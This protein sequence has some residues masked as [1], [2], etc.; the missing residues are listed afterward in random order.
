LIHL[1]IVGKGLLLK[2]QQLIASSC[3]QKI[4]LALSTTG[5]THV[6]NLVRIINSTYNQVNCNLQILEEEGIIKI[7]HYGHMK[8]IELEKENPKTQALL[9][10]LQILNLPSADSLAQII[11]NNKV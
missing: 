3:R 4:L 7:K 1:E 9:K 6:T 2:L 11:D 5:K 8:M 10:A